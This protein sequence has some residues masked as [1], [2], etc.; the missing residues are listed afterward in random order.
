MDL[1]YTPEEVAFRDEIRTFFREKIPAE[2][3]KKGAEGHHASKE[4]MILCQRIMNQHGLATPA[5]RWNGAA[6]IGRPCSASSTPRK[7]CCTTCRRRCRS[8]WPW[9]AR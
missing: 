7:S 9:W 8:T 2:I 1:R 3:R 5:G 6:R 4:D